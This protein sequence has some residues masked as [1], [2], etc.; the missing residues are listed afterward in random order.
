MGGG[1]LSLPRAFDGSS[2]QTNGSW[3]APPGALITSSDRNA[4]LST[5]RCP[6]ASPGLPR[7]LPNGYASPATR[8]VPTALVKGV[9]IVSVSVEMPAASITLAASPTDR[10]QNGQAGTKSATSTSS[11]RIRSIIPGTLVLRNSSGF[12]R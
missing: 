12:N 7:H 5:A 6:L 2:G 9:S 4:A 3:T 10:Q 11:E 1:S 8:G